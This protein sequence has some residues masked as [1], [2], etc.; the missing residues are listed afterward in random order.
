MSVIPSTAADEVAGIEAVQAKL[1]RDRKDAVAWSRAFETHSSTR[2]NVESS[3]FLSDDDGDPA[4][5]AVGSGARPTTGTLLLD[6]L[7]EWNAS[8]PRNV[9]LA[10]ASLIAGGI[11]DPVDVLESPLREVLDLFVEKADAGSNADHV[12]TALKQYDAAWSEQERSRLENTLSAIG[13]GKPSVLLKAPVADFLPVLQDI[14]ARDP[15]TRRPAPDAKDDS[16]RSLLELLRSRRE[17][18]DA[19]AHEQLLT[20]L[21]QLGLDVEAPDSPASSDAGFPTQPDEDAAVSSHADGSLESLLETLT[22]VALGRKSVRAELADML[23]G[24]GV[25]DPDNV[26]DGT[27]ADALELLLPE[28]EEASGLHAVL[29]L[30]K[31]HAHATDHDARMAI[32]QKLT[33][34]GVVPDPD[35][36]LALKLEDT[37]ALLMQLDR[38]AKASAMPGGDVPNFSAALK[39]QIEALSDPSL[40]L[41]RRAVFLERIRMLVL[42][43][44]R[45]TAQRFTERADRDQNFRLLREQLRLAVEGKPLE[46]IAA[47]ETLASQWGV[48]DPAALMARFEAENAR[49]RFEEFIRNWFRFMMPELVQQNYRKKL[50]IAMNPDADGVVDLEAFVERIGSAADLP[51]FYRMLGLLSRL[52]GPVQALYR[53]ELAQYWGVLDPLRL[54]NLLGF[55]APRRQPTRLRVKIPRL[56]LHSMDDRSDIDLD[57]YEYL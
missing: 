10:M 41:E 8:R 37:L 27:L 23:A 44:D 38:R 42:V 5:P 56:R 33:R 55:A 43:Q 14:F 9:R 51:P 18:G 57:L 52:S 28:T 50:L 53:E 20:K 34:H 29:K 16:A 13:L 7:S 48:T 40:S 17:R 25:P 2:M 45:A 47:G 30:L 22:I 3:V 36:L 35:K 6:R 4:Q 32:W 49:R 19:G 26:L 12:L 46:R 24:E 11:P 54:A 31:D 39:I 21:A 1:S 15:S